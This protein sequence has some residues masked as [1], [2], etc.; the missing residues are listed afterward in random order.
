MTPTP[1]EAIARAKRVLDDRINAIRQAV[2][3]RQHVA[4]VREETN[5]QRAEL[6]AQLARL[7]QDAERADIKAYHAAISSG[8]STDELRKIGL[9]EPPKACARR[10]SARKP[11]A[12]RSA[13][14]VPPSDD[15]EAVK[16]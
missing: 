16:S 10:R 15:R 8:W 9:P 7:M 2:A 13:P 11:S 6:E 3:A 1:E 14:P 12:S 5:R 4:D